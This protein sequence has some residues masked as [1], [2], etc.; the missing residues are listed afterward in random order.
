M[1]F[2]S[3]GSYQNSPQKWMQLSRQS[4]TRSLKWWTRLGPKSVIFQPLLNWIIRVCVSFNSVI[5]IYNYLQEGSRYTNIA[6]NWRSLP[7]VGE[8][9][10]ALFTSK[11]HDI[12]RMA[13]VGWVALACLFYYLFTVFHLFW[14][15]LVVYII[16]CN[17][18]GKT[19]K[20]PTD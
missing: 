6:N 7:V 4:A 16:S 14:R 19:V 2:Y 17:P 13:A 5:T 20:L 10:H 3:P 18:G 8:L 15:Y 11:H 12:Y 1:H 9:E